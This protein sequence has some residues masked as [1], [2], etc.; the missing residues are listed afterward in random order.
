MSDEWCRLI[1]DFEQVPVG[2][3]RHYMEECIRKWE[4]M[5]V[6]DVK[7]KCQNCLEPH[8]ESI[9]DQHYEW[10]EEVW[11]CKRFLK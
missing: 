5:N 4:D 7:K 3:R 10:V 11:D 2:V 8:G 9:D 1:H 6:K